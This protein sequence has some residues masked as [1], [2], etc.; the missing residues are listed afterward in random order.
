MWN[1]N[2]DAQRSPGH[3]FF[4][5]T[6]FRNVRACSLKSMTWSALRRHAIIRHSGADEAKAGLLASDAVDNSSP[7][8]LLSQFSER[9]V[10]QPI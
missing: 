6:S 8:L 7:C 10:T 2:L 3:K 9:R 1:K 5:E 4:F